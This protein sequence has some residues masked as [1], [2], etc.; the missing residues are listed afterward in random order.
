[1][2]G[3]VILMLIFNIIAHVNDS[4]HKYIKDN[5]LQTSN[6][7]LLLLISPC[8]AGTIETAITLK[9]PILSAGLIG[10]TIVIFYDYCEKTV[11]AK[12]LDNKIIATVYKD[13]AKLILI[14]YAIPTK[15]L[16]KIGVLERRY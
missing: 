1:M 8:I 12:I 2:L 13:L 9:P 16:Q 4:F 11:K 7:W 14:A 3:Y 5:D 10:W 6:W 15:F